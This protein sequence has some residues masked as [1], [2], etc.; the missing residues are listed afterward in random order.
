[1]TLEN[2]RDVA[3]ICQTQCL[4]FRISTS[5]VGAT[6]AEAATF[7][8]TDCPDFTDCFFGFVIR[9][10]RNPRSILASPAPLVS[11]MPK[12]AEDSRTPKPSE[13]DGS[14]KIRL[15]F[16]VRLSSAAL[17]LPKNN[18]SLNCH[19]PVTACHGLCHD[20]DL[21]K[22]PSLLSCHDVTTYTP[23]SLAKPSGQI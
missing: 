23:L 5:N 6:F 9:V 20:L 8:T 3:R 22:R 13:F 14:W 21:K 7:L 2:H 19:D 16:G 12:G 17:T 10:F 15:R 11:G 1:V 18:S 4:G